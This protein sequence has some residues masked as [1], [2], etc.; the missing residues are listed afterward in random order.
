MM[1]R[2]ALLPGM[3]CALLLLGF[4]GK[5]LLL[6]P[7]SPP[8]STGAGDFDTGRALARLERILGDQR[9]HPVD[10]EANDSVRGR[11]IAELRAIGLNPRVQE[12]VDCSAMP[13][14]RVV[15]CSRVRNVIATVAAGPGKHVLLNAHYDSTPTGPGAADDGIGVAALLEIAALLKD[16]PP[17]RP[18]TFLFNEGE[19]FGLN[20]ASAFVREEALADEVDSLV[21]IESRGVSGPAIMFET[22]Q[23]NGAAIAA[24][25]GAA[26]R[27]YANSLSMDFA[28][29]IPNTTDVVEFRTAGWTVLNYAIIGNETRYHTPGDTI[30]ALDPSSLHHVGTEALAATRL[31][32]AGNPAQIKAR[33]LVFTDIAGRLFLQLRLP[34]AAVA[35]DLLL[36]LA[37]VQAYR[38]KALGRPMLVS[39]AMVFGGIA[40]AAITG[41]AAG[42]LRPGDFWRAYPL[43]TYLA[44]YAVTLLAMA[45]VRKR[46]GEPLDPWRLRTAVWLL[47]LFL[48]AVVSIFLPGAMIYFLVAPA[49]ALAGILLS[50]RSPRAAAWLAVAAALVQFVMFAQLLGLIELLLIDGP[51][52]AVAPLAVLAALPFMVETDPGRLGPLLLALVITA[53]LL[54]FA[55]LL[56]PRGSAD[57]PAAFNIDYFRDDSAGT[58]KWAV[59]SKQAPLPGDFPGR[60]RKAILDYSPRTRW[61]ADAPLIEVPRPD[62]R[63]I[64]NEPAGRGRRVWLVLLPNGAGAMSVRLAE[65]AALQRLGTPGESLAVPNKGRPDKALI[66]CSGRSCDGMV[67]EMLLADR[68]PVVADLFATRFGLPPEGAHLAVRRPANTHPQYGPDSSIR[69]RLIRF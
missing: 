9:P 25:A 5:G 53:A 67:L 18:V 38:R 34:I 55:A 51:I 62:V 43:V 66:R 61:V 39:A 40:A 10:S 24:F 27:P 52:Y 26:R 54:W 60:W 37:L 69:R 47:I 64:R 14:S 20:G 45:A 44:I 36:L 49:I 23:P 56:L 57:R 22:S 13:N 50:R 7:S 48:G 1:P 12:A 59:A 8:S 31:L 15:S 28:K 65:S 21:N 11:L 63:M 19:E 68:K 6:L 32:A 46:F 2:R 3:L 42:L 4:A 33:T 58:G 30:A 35:L 41:V 29:L 17:A 16:R